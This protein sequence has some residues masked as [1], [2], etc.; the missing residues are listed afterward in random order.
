MLTIIETTAEVAGAPPTEVADG[1]GTIY[2][3][4]DSIT[5]GA[6]NN[7]IIGG[8]GHDT[9]LTGNG[10][11]TVLGD[12]GHAE[13]NPAIPVPAAPYILVKVNSTYGSAAVGGTAAT[14][15][16]SADTITLGDGANT[17]IA[18]AGADSVTVGNG[19]NTIIGDDGQALYTTGKL[20]TIETT[21]PAIGGDDTIGAGTGNNIII[22]GLGADGI[23]AGGGNDVVI[24]DSAHVEWLVTGE[25]SI[26]YTTSPE[27][28][29]GGTP[30]TGSSSNDT[31]TLGAGN[32]V[33]F[34][35]SGADRIT[36]GVGNSVI[37][38]D[39]GQ[40]TYLAGVLVDVVTLSADLGGDDIIQTGDG[41][42]VVFGGLGA[43]QI[44]VGDGRDIVLGDSGHVDIA[45][46]GV[47][48]QVYSLF[49]DIVGGGT[50]ATGS[51]SNDTILGNNGTYV[52]IGGS[53]AD[54]I[55]LNNGDNYILGDNGIVQF[56][57]IAGVA[58][59]S[60]A[61]TTFAAF[62]GNDV[63]VLGNGENSVIGGIGD[64]RITAGTGADIVIGDSGQIIQE[65][66]AAGAVVRNSGG[67]RHRDIVL[68]T[69]G[70]IT[71]QIALDSAGNAAQSN[72]SNI[73]SAGLILLAGAYDANG[74]RVLTNGNWQTDAL[75]MS[76]TADGNDTIV[77]GNGNNV[78]VGQGGN[79][80]ITAGNGNNLI[81]GNGASVTAPIHDDLPYIVNAVLVIGAVNGIDIT[82]PADG[83]LV[84]PNVTLLPSALTAAA[85]QL[86]LGPSG[87]GT[88]MDLAGG[89]MLARANSSARLSVFASIVPDM[90]HGSSALPGSNTIVV[91][92]GNNT[93]FGNYGSIGV[94][95]TTGISAIDTELQGL[96]VTMLGVLTDLSSLSYA[97]DA[98]AVAQ[99][100]GTPFAVSFG[101]NTITAN[102]GNN[103]IYG[104]SGH[105]YLTNAGYALPTSG[106]YVQNVSNF[107]S[108]LVDM[109]QALADLSYVAHEAGQQTINTFAALP[110]S[111]AAR[112]AAHSLTFD[113][114]TINTGNGS[115][116]VV[117]NNAFVFVPGVPTA[118][119]DWTSNGQAGAAQAAAA[120]IVNAGRAATASHLA[121]NHPLS[122]WNANANTVFGNGAGYILS[123]DNNTITGGAGA[124]V[125]IGNIG[126]IEQPVV[127]SGIGA[128]D[129]ASQSQTVLLNSVDRL[130]LGP[131]T[132]STSWA[133]AIGVQ[134]DMAARGLSDASRNAGFSFTPQHPPRRRHDRDRKRQHVGLW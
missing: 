19:N 76:L 47:V 58:N 109:Q 6:G 3:G 72:L 132:G 48:Q 40:A 37:L 118:G 125:L 55:T 129:L 16:S 44:T 97:Q 61:S 101:N 130:F 104:N 41:N 115:N 98:L 2:G 15:T 89:G 23:T 105:I 9:I 66:D 117:G 122:V 25:R 91:G 99:G 95:P 119:L 34:G 1:T 39:N 27:I 64:D 63:I 22:G 110:G 71:S 35:G 112:A 49:A 73:S 18:G 90:L 113:D 79:N 24:G 131:Y 100:A 52:V 93:I 126:L 75:L 17:V 62:G 8:L 116:I 31:I 51:S 94:L 36:T 77:V 84:V 60:R 21:D 7:V 11:N 20:T 65:F 14:G 45:S 85:P 121:A 111:G 120:A 12:S 92:S 87:T 133:Y 70:T 106:S 123:V 127:V 59:V 80:S 68:E 83:Q 28:T 81:F 53:G 107:A 102:G 74:N 124:N 108:H 10:S 38:G 54:S 114:N 82:V 78:V 86:D 29:G 57:D 103:S 134:P 4:D 46:N 96:S 50:A 43:D 30:A 5:A 32:D 88:L 128:Q 67:D 69:V 13:F 26:A 42:N 56:A 33:V